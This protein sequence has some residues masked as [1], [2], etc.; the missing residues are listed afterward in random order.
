MT[1]SRPDTNVIIGS[2]YLADLVKQF[3]GDSTSIV[4]SYNAGPSRI[5]RWRKSV[6]TITDQ[7]LQ[8]LVFIETIPIFE[9]R[10]YVKHVLANRAH[11]D[12]KLGRSA[13][14]QYDWLLRPAGVL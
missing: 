4:A 13:G 14:K 6:T 5:K 8:Q 9:T 10:L 12:A 7:L 1:S 11:Y 3:K 2:R